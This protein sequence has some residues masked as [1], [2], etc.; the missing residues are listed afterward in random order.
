[1]DWRKLQRNRS[2]YQQRELHEPRFDF[3]RRQQSWTACKYWSKHHGTLLGVSRSCKAHENA[4]TRKE[5]YRAHHQYYINNRTID[6]QLCSIIKTSKWPLSSQQVIV[7]KCLLK[8]QEISSFFLLRHSAKAITECVRQELLYMD[9]NVKIT[10]ISP[11]LVE[12]D[13]IHS[14]ISHEPALSAKDVSSACLYAI[15]VKDN[16]QVWQEWEN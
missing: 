9:E 7:D 12:N 2:S 4:R 8:F 3:A 10:A 14:E 5:K 15:S 1:M 11:G 13:T 16:V 6:R